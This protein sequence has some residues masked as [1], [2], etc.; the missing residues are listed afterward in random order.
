MAKKK[1][2]NKSLLLIMEGNLQKDC[3]NTKAK[4][5]RLRKIRNNIVNKEY[6]HVITSVLKYDREQVLEKEKRERIQQKEMEMKKQHIHANKMEFLKQWK[7]FYNGCAMMM[8]M[9]FV[10]SFGSLYFLSP[11]DLD[12]DSSYR[13][14]Y[15]WY[16]PD[17]ANGNN[18]IHPYYGTCKELFKPFWGRDKGLHTPLDYC[19][20]LVTFSCE[21][22]V[23]K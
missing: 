16:S 22:Y 12:K 7:S 6:V 23:K 5:R 8:P 4:N 2:K 11:V 13:Y 14:N 19:G 1:I 10:W 20:N 17:Y 21:E 3:K 18:M 15:I 9:H